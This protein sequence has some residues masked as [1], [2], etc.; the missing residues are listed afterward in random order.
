MGAELPDFG[1]VSPEIFEEIILPQLGA[2]DPRV[3][4]GPQ[5]G[6][7]VGIV[8]V[9]D[10]ALAITCDPV[11]IV[12]EYG[13]ERAAWFAIHILASD[14][15][16]RRAIRRPAGSRK[17]LSSATRRTAETPRT[18]SVRFMMRSRTPLPRWSPWVA[19]KVSATCMA[20]AGNM[21]ASSIARRRANP[22]PSAG[23]PS[24]RSTIWAARVI[25]VPVVRPKSTILIEVNHARDR[26][27]NH[28]CMWP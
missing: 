24:K 21:C 13:W 27:T 3:L 11:F 17:R 5:S 4:V 2:P 19:G 26:R 16:T 23:R 14:A 12:P 6:V 10:T 1:K 8:E 25:C 28:C 22:A 9:G 18:S 15:V 20:I 7:D